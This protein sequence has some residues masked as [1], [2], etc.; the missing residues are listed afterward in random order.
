MDAVRNETDAERYDRN[1]LELVQEVRVAQT[2][3]QILAGFLLM[4]PF[5][6]RFD[7]IAEGYRALFL[8]AFSLAVLTTGLMIAPVLMH[9][10]LFRRQAKD[11]VV[12]IGNGIVK[13]AMGSLGL[14]MVAVTALIFG[15]VVGSTAS[16]VAGSVV[17][18]FYVLVW[19]VLPL[20][21]QRRLLDS[22]ASG[23]G[24]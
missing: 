1:W 19:V 22:G 23:G 9:R 11:T 6:E 17:L 18:T 24:G 12:R 14:T 10:F 13:L 3:V 16:V 5:T 15:V 7:E 2:G 8:V 4:L 20:A 21:V